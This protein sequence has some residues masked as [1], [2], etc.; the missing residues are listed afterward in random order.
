MPKTLISSLENVD[1]KT[2]YARL[3]QLFKSIPSGRRDFKP[4]ERPCS[5]RI[6]KSPCAISPKATFSF[7][8]WEI[9]TYATHS[10]NFDFFEPYGRFTKF[11]LAIAD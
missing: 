1:F 11:L 4:V 5:Q 10:Y 6:R 8:E 3:F 2:H 9:V 7:S